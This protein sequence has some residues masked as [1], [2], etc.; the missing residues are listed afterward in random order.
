M[1]DLRQWLIALAV[2]VV[3]LPGAGWLGARYGKQMRGNVMMASILLGFGQAMDPAKETPIEAAEGRN[4]KAP[5]P[6]G[7]PPT[8]IS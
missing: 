5:V 8:P 1:S 3:V 7:E 2:L 6:P 4:E